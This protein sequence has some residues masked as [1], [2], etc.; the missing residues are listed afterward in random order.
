MFLFYAQNWRYESL[1]KKSLS[2]HLPPATSGTIRCLATN[3][4]GTNEKTQ[5]VVVNDLEEDMA[6][7]SSEVSVGSNRLISVTCA[8]ST[9]HFKEVNWFK[10]GKLV[11]NSGGE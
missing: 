10:N 2:V 1:D 7:W 9:F 8:A 3:D 6:I 11:E 4:W 5:N